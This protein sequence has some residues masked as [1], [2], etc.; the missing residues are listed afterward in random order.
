[1][2]NYHPCIR[3]FKQNEIKKFKMML[4]ESQIKE[5]YNKALALL[6]IKR[7]MKFDFKDILIPDSSLC[8]KAIEEAQDSFNFY[9]ILSFI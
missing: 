2:E 9:F 3:N 6:N 8:S 5:K 1:M 7:Y 4:I